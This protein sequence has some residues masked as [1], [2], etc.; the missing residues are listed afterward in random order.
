MPW[1]LPEPFSVIPVWSPVLPEW[2][3][4]VA[5]SIGLA[6]TLA[7]LLCLLVGHWLYLV[8]RLRTRWAAL[9]LILLVGSVLV[10]IRLLMDF[11]QRMAFREHL[12]SLWGLLVTFLAVA[13]WAGGRQMVLGGTDATRSHGAFSVALWPWILV[14]LGVL[15]V[16]HLWM[17]SRGPE[18]LKTL[19]NLH[20]SPDGQWLVVS[21]KPWRGGSYEPVY[22]VHGE[23][24]ESQYLGPRFALPGFPIFS[25]QS[26]AV[27]WVRCPMTSQDCVLHWQELG[28]QERSASMAIERE[29]RQLY[30]NYRN[31]TVAVNDDGFRVAMAHQSRLEVYALP[32][33]RLLATQRLG[34][35]SN[36]H[37]NFEGNDELWVYHQIMRPGDLYVDFWRLGLEDSDWSYMGA[38]AGHF[39]ALHAEA[40]R[41]LLSQFP[42]R[43][44]LLDRL[45]KQEHGRH[46][47][48][49]RPLMSSR[50]L[51]TGQVVTVES[52][53]EQVF[54]LCVYGT[55]G[56]QI[57]SET[58]E[59]GFHPLL[60]GEIEA[61]RLLVGRRFGRPTA[62]PPSD[63]QAWLPGFG[64]VA[65]WQTQVF[66][67]SEGWVGDP[68]PGVLP[69]WQVGHS[70]E[71]GRW[72]LSTQ[73]VQRLED[74]T[75]GQFS[76]RL[77]LAY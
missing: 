64:A 63:A 28:G 47:E 76:T 42:G 68:W 11:Y 73:G 65:D 32:E 67:A 14:M 8:L 69:A 74:V 12:F 17:V 51:T 56:R 33:L 60:G 49:T 58:F 26:K 1:S 40:D 43:L 4:P 57:F 24:G 27:V 18:D 70:F 16:V 45:G 30:S 75:E 71:Q 6:W 53:S 52:D 46:M 9:D 13:L 29:Y 20:A 41:L 44:V 36:A 15:F 66:D 55:D 37:L 7:S 25:A 59:E 34:N 3:N 48:S 38:S 77:P 23:S 22:L 5:G 62:S 21:G 31:R 54:S 10:L 35:H 19:E 2:L 50:L 61:G 39:R 72:L